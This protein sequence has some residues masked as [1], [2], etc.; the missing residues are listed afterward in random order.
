[1]ILAE[2]SSEAITRYL[3]TRILLRNPSE[4]ELDSTLGFLGKNPSKAKLADL[5]QTLLV[6]NEFFFVD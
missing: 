2:N 3:F 5:A 1:M 4:E 6:S